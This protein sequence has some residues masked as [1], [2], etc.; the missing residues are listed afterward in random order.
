MGCHM[1]LLKSIVL[2][3]IGCMFL[4]SY[5][6]ADQ[7]GDYT[8]TVALGEATITG[9]TGTGGDISIPA[10]LGG[11]P[12]V[13]I[14]DY[15]FSNGEINNTTL[16]SVIIPSSVTTIGIDAFRRYQCNKFNYT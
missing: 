13:A 2:L 15:A 5:A 6:F 1:Q 10:A 3:L 11:Y 12:T 4:S 7:D 9:Y 16:T 14:G 8:Y